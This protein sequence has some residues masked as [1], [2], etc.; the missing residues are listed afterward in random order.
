VSY[1]KTLTDKNLKKHLRLLSTDEEIKVIT[2]YSSLHL[3]ERFVVHLLFPGVVFLVIGA[4]WAFFLH[5]ELIYGVA[6]GLIPAAAL[7]ALVTW[8]ISKSHRFILTTRRI[9]LREGFFKVKVSSVLYDKVTHISVDQSLFDRLVLRHGTI[10]IDTSGSSGDELVLKYVDE[11]I[12][13]KNIL[14]HLIHKHQS[15][16]LQPNLAATVA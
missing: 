4:G 16:H 3:R 7:S 13:F 9:I 11:P 6:L 8:I 1:E 2:G 14:E 5:W 12:K 15:S 10:V